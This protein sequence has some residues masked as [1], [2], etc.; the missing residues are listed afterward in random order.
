MQAAGHEEVLRLVEDRKL[1]IQGIGWTGAHLP[2]LLSNCG[3]WT[4]DQSL[5]RAAH[6]LGPAS[7][8]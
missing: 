1:W 3:L 2:S 4:L 8:A 6:A 5:G 7:R